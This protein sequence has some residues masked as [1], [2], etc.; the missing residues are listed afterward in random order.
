MVQTI[1]PVV[2]G[3]SRRR[4]AGPVAL[5]VLGAGLS[6]AILGAA[7]GAIGSI[8]GAPW[9]RAG[10]LFVAVIGLAYAARELLR[11]PI[12][13]PEMRRQVPE[14]WRGVLGP[15]TVAFLY[16]IA[17]GPGFPTHLR[18]GTFVAVA[19]AAVALG[20]PWL[21]VAMLAPFGIAR[22]LGVAL[23]SAGRTEAALMAAGDRLERL[24]AGPLPR[25]A[26]GLALLVM[27]LVASFSS[28]TAGSAAS[29]LWPALLAGTFAWA[30]AAKLI[31]RERWAEALRAQRLPRPIEALAERLIPLSEAT[32]VVLLLLGRV[33]AGAA[34]ALL[35]LTAFALALLRARR[36]EDGALPCGCF[37]GR[38]RRSL[39]WLLG[40][41]AGLGILA[42]LTLW[43]GAPVTPPPMPRAGELIPASLAVLGAALATRLLLRAVSLLNAERVRR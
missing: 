7:L 25:V 16:G 42:V 5:H 29:W 18:H 34:L 39:S 1:T 28:S 35:L 32:V 23:A 38:S 6:A 43:A 27:S 24:G 40:R 41:N 11:L 21:G 30:A 14:W 36:F 9:G 31:R 19:A 26:N 22:A 3:G 37:G 4:W 13:V 17:L 12:P 20:E 8:G 10:M 15:R 33:R 2:H